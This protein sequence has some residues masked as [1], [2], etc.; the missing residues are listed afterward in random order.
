MGP[1]L[2]KY[3]FKMLLR[4]HE[5]ATGPNASYETSNAD[6]GVTILTNTKI[7]E[8]HEVN[9]R[10]SVSS[11]IFFADL[12]PTLPSRDVRAR[13]VELQDTGEGPRSSRSHEWKE[14][15]DELARWDDFGFATHGQVKLMAHI[16][17]ARNNFKL[18]EAA[19]SWID[20]VEF[21]VGDIVPPSRMQRP[22]PRI[23]RHK[24]AV[25][26]LNLHEWYVGRHAQYGTEF[27]D[28]RETL[29]LHSRSIIGG[30][31][32]LRESYEAVG[33]VNPRFHD[34]DHPDQKMRTANGYGAAVPGIKKVISAINLGYHWGGGVLREPRHDYLLPV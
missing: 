32:A 21:R 12:P 20:S 29:W 8:S 1:Y 2:G 22:L 26:E 27:L 10:L 7:G 24:Q 5:L 6:N 19:I 14:E 33:I 28:F 18:V 17:K 11:C 23:R 25:G 13:K 34:F 4:Q 16:I 3:A 30:L 9:A 31:F 15:D